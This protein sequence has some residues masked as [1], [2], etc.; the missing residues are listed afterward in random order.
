M[1]RLLSPG[2][3]IGILGGGQ[4]G[5]MMAIA[6]KTMGFRIAVLEPKLNSPTGQVADVEV[7]AAYDDRE[8]AKELAKHC[9]VLTYEF[10]NIDAKTARFL[11]E[12][13]YLPQGGSLLYTTQHRVREKTAIEQA[14]VRVSPYKP[15][16]SVD[17]LQQ[18]LEELGRPAVLKTCQGGYDGKGQVVIQEQTSAEEAFQ[19]LNGSENDLVLEAWVPFEK[20]I[21]VIVTRSTNG[22][23][24]T[25]P[26][27][28]NI[29]VNNILHQTIVPARIQTETEEKAR[30]IA[31]TL[32]EELDL[33]GTLA[34][35][36]FVLENGDIFVNELAPRPH[37]SGHY[38]IEACET[39]QFEQHV[40]A[41]CGWPLGST[42]LLKPVV[43]TNILGQHIPYVMENITR[44]SE[45]GHV[46]IYGKD[47][48][49]QGRKMG[50]WTVL[51]DN[52]EEALAKIN[53]I[54]EQQASYQK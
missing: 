7:E 23:T 21:S 28:E 8:G 26:V 16:D 37:N 6:A 39:S 5:R 1:S 36:M 2:K 3:T 27:G 44:F 29:H 54:W 13:L 18:A 47:E 17:S 9:D 51:A 20:E 48:A 49:K 25:F 34:V 22:E 24:S 38:T 52:T 53:D 31:D 46:H 42:G 30:Q 19:T 50:H 12:T 14:G 4:L 41:V 33:V 32:A 40:R 11:E 43:M 15:V 35:E 45:R 10:E